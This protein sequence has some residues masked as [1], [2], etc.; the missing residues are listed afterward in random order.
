MSY[1][2]NSLIDHA[3]AVYFRYERKR[4]YNPDRVDQPNRY[5][6]EQ[7]GDKI[8]IRNAYRTLAIYRWSGKRLVRLWIEDFPEESC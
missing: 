6:T 4:A 1:Y 8:F 3:V 2:D 7:E 5:A